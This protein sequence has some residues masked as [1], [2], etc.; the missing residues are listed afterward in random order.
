MRQGAAIMP[1]APIKMHNHHLLQLQLSQ[2]HIQASIKTLL[3]VPRQ[4]K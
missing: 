4:K 3:F 2:M 1:H